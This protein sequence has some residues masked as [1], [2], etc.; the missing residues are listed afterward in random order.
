MK[1][2]KVA[3]KS[4]LTEGEMKGVEVDDLKLLLTLINGEVHA[5]SGSCTH[6]GAPLADGALSGTQVICPWHHACFDVTTGDHLE[7]PGLNALKKFEVRLDGDDVYVTLPN[8][9][10]GEREPRATSQHDDERTFVVVG[11]GDAGQSAAETL[12]DEGFTGRLVM[13]SKEDTAPY[14]RTKL[15]KELESTEKP[16]DLELR[17]DSFYEKRTIERLVKEVTK[18]DVNGK[19]VTF[20][21]GETLSFD[22]LVIATGG[23]PKKLD[24]AGADLN[25]VHTLRSLEDAKHIYSSAHKGSKAV[26][27]GSS[28]IALELANALQALDVEVAVVARESVPFA[29]ILGE[30]LGKHIQ[31]KH[32]A[33]NVTFYL[34]SEPESFEGDEKV[35]RVV[36]ADGTALE[37]D[38][39]VVGIGVSPVTDIAEGVE[40]AD[41]GGIKV[42]A[43]L[44]AA[45]AVYAAG[46]VAE[47]PLAATGEPVRIEHWR[48]AAQHGRTAARNMLGQNAA[49][50]GVPY[51]WT[52]QP[53]LKLRYVGHVEEFDDI[54]Y[55]GEV[56]SGEF[57]AYYLK[58]GKVRAAAGS[59]RDKDMAALEHLMR[60]GDTPTPDDLKEGVKVLERL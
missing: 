30:R 4:E 40:K 56:E 44:K 41:D 36:L 55:D 58:D 35:A 42:D 25:G 29:G 47:F 18:V 21:G 19:T 16:A 10:D 51:F 39:V 33:Q 23:T 20:E 38:F 15:S 2:H 9:T 14:D 57:L 17:P 28:F 54:V 49:F 48:L 43:T 3:N 32:E 59:N 11:G 24:I 34:E 7:P 12:R 53:D 52:A 46:D 26:L 8:E 31:S 50:E 22:A 13:I 60:R 37:A 6:Y 5:V 27:I 1:E 45:D